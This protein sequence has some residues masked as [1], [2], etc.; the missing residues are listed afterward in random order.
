MGLGG[1]SR[2]S[3]KKGGIEGWSPPPQWHTRFRAHR[4]SIHRLDKDCCSDKAFFIVSF[5]GILCSM[6]LLSLT[7]PKGGENGAAPPQIIK[8]GEM[9]LL[10]S[11]EVMPSTKKRDVFISGVEFGKYF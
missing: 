1:S 10:L 7:I 9:E 6:L 11:L 4:A 5:W 2:E 3:E 8:K